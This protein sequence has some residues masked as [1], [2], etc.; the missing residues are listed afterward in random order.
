ME[1]GQHRKA[2]TAD[3]ADIRPRKWALGNLPFVHHSVSAKL[4]TIIG[5]KP[6]V[7][8]RRQALRNADVATHL[9]RYLQGIADQAR[10]IV[11]E[12]HKSDQDVVTRYAIYPFIKY[13]SIGRANP[14]V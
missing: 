13:P 9:S 10:L 11:I 8:Q 3:M 4:S 14:F 6:F 12:N 1:A 7:P 2:A 5:T